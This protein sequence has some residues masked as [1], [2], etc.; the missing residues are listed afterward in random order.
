MSNIDIVRAWKDASYLETLSDEAR[1]LVPANPVGELELT[2]ADLALISG[3]IVVSKQ[4][5]TMSTG[6]GSANSPCYCSC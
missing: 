4:P 5:P 1:A 6:T 3:G 2:D